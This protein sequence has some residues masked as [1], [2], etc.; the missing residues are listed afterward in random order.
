MVSTPTILII[1]GTGM[2]GKRLVEHLAMTHDL[3]AKLLITSRS[4]TKADDIASSIQAQHPQTSIQGMAFDR[5]ADIAAVFKRLKPKIIVDCSGPFQSANYELAR[6]ALECG[7]NFI[8]LADARDYIENFYEALNGLASKND[9]TAV[10]G[11]ST[12]P[13]LSANVVSAL[14][15]GWQ[16]IDNIELAIT[17]GGKSEVGLSVMQALLSYAGREIPAWK[18]G[19]PAS[20]YGLT[21]SKIMNVP[22]LGKRRIIEVETIDATYLGKR[23][24]V[25]SDVTFYTGLESVIEQWGTICLGYLV[26]WGIIKNPTPLAPLL[27]K[28]RGLI[29]PFTSDRGGMVIYASGLD[30]NGKEVA[31]CWSLLATQG[32][33]PFV[34][35]LPMAAAIKKLLE[36]KIKTGAMIADVALKLVEIEAEMQIHNITTSIEVH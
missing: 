6:A 19:K 14:T 9:L 20:I 25:T 2:F 8:D 16:R 30:A 29:R 3:N 34:P 23:Y 24:N 35:I 28:V 12:T 17:P 18:D 1:G 36:G 10:T 15:K 4:Q 26:K 22:N 31:A 7:S 21:K 27:M 13:A 32:D 33:G 11:A 5:G